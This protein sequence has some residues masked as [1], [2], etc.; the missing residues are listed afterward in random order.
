MFLEELEN[1]PPSSKSQNSI[2]TPLVNFTFKWDFIEKRYK[3]DKESDLLQ[4]GR[5]DRQ[6]LVGFLQQLHSLPQMNPKPRS[7]KSLAFIGIL[8]L[9]VLTFSFL[10]FTFSAKGNNYIETETK[11]TTSTNPTSVP[12]TPNQIP[13]LNTP[14]VASGTALTVVKGRQAV[15]YFWTGTRIFFLVLSII[16]LIGIAFL[17]YKLFSIK[18][19]NS[20]IL[21]SR[22]AHINTFLQKVNFL[23]SGRGL[24]WYSSPKCSYLVLDC[25]Y[26]QGVI[27]EQ[28]EKNQQMLNTNSNLNL[29]QDE[30]FKP[31]F[32][33]VYKYGVSQIGV[34][35]QESPKKLAKTWSN[36]SQKYNQYN[37]YDRNYNN[38]QSQN[39]QI[40][41]LQSTMD[42]DNFAYVLKTRNS[43]R[44]EEQS[45]IRAQ[46]I[47]KQ[48]KYPTFRFKEN[49][50]PTFGQENISTIDYPEW[51]TKNSNIEQMSNTDYYEDFQGDKTSGGY[52]VIHVKVPVI[53][54]MGDNKRDNFKSKQTNQGNFQKIKEVDYLNQMSIALTLNNTDTV[55]KGRMPWD[56]L[57]SNNQ[58]QYEL[59]RGQNS[60]IEQVA[61]KDIDKRYG[62]F[63]GGMYHDQSVDTSNPYGVKTQS[64]IFNNFN[65]NIKN[66]PKR[67]ISPVIKRS[68]TREKKLMPY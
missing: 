65:N 67:N 56:A 59:G 39:Q 45:N 53:K 40:R 37:D 64:S 61:V 68:K 27:N 32:G 42:L 58:H 23:I 41:D 7:S 16:V 19:D 29:V 9:V 8:L 48:L 60:E 47:E 22:K 35:N 13:P 63:Q 26:T 50:R 20:K 31:R 3:C 62:N 34:G 52:N 5:V 14:P 24:K 4:S 1:A 33:E 11:T 36:D 51:K 10:I 30:E 57:D 12:I 18:K 44:D 55:K 38:N 54:G 66:N 17:A 6:E 25:E 28:Q 49:E 43:A 15:P 2:H 21:T 46:N